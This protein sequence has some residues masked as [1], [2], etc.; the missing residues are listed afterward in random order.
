MIGDLP[1]GQDYSERNPNEP[2]CK[3]FQRTRTNQLSLSN[4][5][6]GRLHRNAQIGDALDA[7]RDALMRDGRGPS[8]LPQGWAPPLLTWRRGIEDG[9]S[10]LRLRAEL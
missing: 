5:I 10:A 2:R 4:E 8:H 3:R 1:E 7:L 6:A 9:T